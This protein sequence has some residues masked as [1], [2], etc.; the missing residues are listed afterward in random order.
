MTRIK[1]DC[2][3]LYRSA[4]QF[5]ISLQQQSCL[6]KIRVIRANPWQKNAL[7][8]YPRPSA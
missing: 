5:P 3:W 1:A 4:I 7:G 8:L 6:D 2:L